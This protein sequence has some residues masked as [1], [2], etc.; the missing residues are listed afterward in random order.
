LIQSNSPPAL[1]LHSSPCSNSRT[2]FALARA[3]GYRS[4]GV[5][6]TRERVEVKSHS[7]D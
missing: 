1:L 6:T 4:V 3:I 5:I 2:I 7:K